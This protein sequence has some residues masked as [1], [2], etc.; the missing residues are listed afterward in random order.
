MKSGCQCFAE[1]TKNPLRYTAHLSCTSFCYCSCVGDVAILTL[2]CVSELLTTLAWKK[3]LV[4]SKL[5]MC[6]KMMKM[7]VCKVRIII[8]QR[9]VTYQRCSPYDLMTQCSI[10]S[11]QSVLHFSI[12]ELP[13]FMCPSFWGLL[14]DSF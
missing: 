2:C 4:I 7:T 14:F 9:M 3:H 5:N 13:G 8:S 11:F 1:G 6:W 12:L 10:T